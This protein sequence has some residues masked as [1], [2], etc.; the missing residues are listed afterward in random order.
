MLPKARPTASAAHAQRRHR[1]RHHHRL[2]E[3]LAPEQHHP[4]L[5]GAVEDVVDDLE[6]QAEVP[7]VGAEVGALP[8]EIGKQI[9][10]SG[11]GGTVATGVD[12]E[13]AIFGL[14][15]GSTQR[16][17]QRYVAGLRQD[18]FEAKLVG[19]HRRACLG[20]VFA[21]AGTERVVE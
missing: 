16:T 1:L 11:N 6:R 21:E 17:I 15:A 9:G 13:I 10:A 7:A 2:G 14:R 18:A 4:R 3:R 8:G 20:N 12:H 19:A 5:V